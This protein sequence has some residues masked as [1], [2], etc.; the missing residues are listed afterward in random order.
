MKRLICSVLVLMLVFSAIPVMVHADQGNKEITYFEDGSYLVSEVTPASTRA[1]G[2]TS[3]TKP[4]TYYSASGRSLWEVTLSGTF[5][6]TGSSATCTDSSV[7]VSV[8]D[9]SWYT[10][11]KSARKSGSSAT[12]S[13]SMSMKSAGVTVMTV[14][15]S[16]SLTCDANGKLS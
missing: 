11:S 4:Y 1:S 2:T 10:A 7:S 15:V 3:G 12:G 6:Y 5:R 14:P 13:A 8:Y 9:S 16:M